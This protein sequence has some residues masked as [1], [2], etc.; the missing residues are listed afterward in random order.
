MTS[1]N[2]V[3]KRIFFSNAAHAHVA[4]GAAVAGL[5]N[6]SHR[7]KQNTGCSLH[8]KPSIAAL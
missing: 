7:Y 6:N 2:F 3:G 5:D 4:R 1:A 8:T